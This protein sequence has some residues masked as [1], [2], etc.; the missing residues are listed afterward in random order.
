MFN[1]RICHKVYFKMISSI[2]RIR[3]LKTYN[4]GIEHFKIK[5]FQNFKI[6]LENLFQKEG[7]PF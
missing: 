7:K 3:K 5:E 4:V 6:I 2:S 1:T